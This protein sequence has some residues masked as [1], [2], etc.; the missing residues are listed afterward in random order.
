VYKSI[1]ISNEGLPWLFLFEVST[2]FSSFVQKV[3][4]HIF[5]ILLKFTR[6]TGMIWIGKITLWWYGKCDPLVCISLLGTACILSH[7]L[8]GI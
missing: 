7:T 5:G 6:Q 4:Q 8:M 2:R 1:N 3:V